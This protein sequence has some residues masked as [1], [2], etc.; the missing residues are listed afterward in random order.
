MTLVLP[1]G[2][3]SV[4]HLTVLK[5]SVYNHYCMDI[6]DYIVKQGKRLN[7]YLLGSELHTFCTLFFLICTMIP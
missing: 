7:I 4:E 5:L 2:G 6:Q 1:A 3:S